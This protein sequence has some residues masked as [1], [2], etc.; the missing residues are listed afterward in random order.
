MNREGKNITIALLLIC[1]L[2]MAV[3]Y[4]ILQQRLNVEGTANVS[5]VWDIQVIGIRE[6]GL[7]GLAE[8]ANVDYTPTSATFNTNL[9]APEDYAFYE[10]VVEN[11]GSLTA[12]SSLGEGIYTKSVPDGYGYGVIFVKDEPMEEFESLKQ[13]QIESEKVG[14]ANLQ[15]SI[16][17]APGEKAYYYAVI[18]LFNVNK[19]P[20]ESA[21]FSID[22]SFTQAVNFPMSKT[23][24]VNLMGTLPK[25]ITIDPTATLTNSSDYTSQQLTI[26]L[27][28][29][30]SVN[31][32]IYSGCQAKISYML[33]DGTE[34]TVTDM[35]PLISAWWTE[36][37][38]DIFTDPTKTEQ[39]INFNLEISPNI[40]KVKNL[41]IINGCL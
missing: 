12:T 2:T 39:I 20:T 26:K 28:R 5:S 6:F 40:D 27:N 22:F 9:N 41:T 11:K 25:G 1:I 4:S 17:L 18:H 16:T 32:N 21:S 30:T 31:T 15:G 33:T 38:L 7:V 3:G 35:T 23:L 34:D 37:E 36:Q 10:I 14:M 24:D 19:L 8:P 13:M 29:D